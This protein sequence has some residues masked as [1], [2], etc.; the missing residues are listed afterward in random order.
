MYQTL[1]LRDV[2]PTCYKNTGF[3]LVLCCFSSAP[4]RVSRLGFA[5][6]T[7]EFNATGHFPIWQHLLHQSY[8]YLTQCR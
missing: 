1:Q 4:F 6:P 2:F 5:D 3:A 8:L 7:Q